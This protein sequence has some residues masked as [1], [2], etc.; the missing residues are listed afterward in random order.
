MYHTTIFLEVDDTL[1]GIGLLERNWEPEAMGPL[2]AAWD[3]NLSPPRW[4]SGL[5]WYV[6]VRGNRVGHYI[7]HWRF[8]W[9]VLLV[10]DWKGTEW[11]AISLNG[12]VTSG[13]IWYV[14]EREQNDTLY[15]LNKRN[16][17]VILSGTW[18]RGNRM[19]CYVLYWRS[20]GVV[21]TWYVTERE[22]N[23]WDN[24]SICMSQS[25]V[26]LHWDGVFRLRA[27]VITEQWKVT[28]FR[29]RL[30]EKTAPR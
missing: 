22:Q 29:L 9:V 17:Q 3:T 27:N 15:I 6:T 23:L 5:M 25:A 26:S 13:L 10:C 18:L 16:D 7:C 21:L 30:Q 14:A 28:V 12:V 4:L 8:D 11:Y 20:D 2:D 19:L 1:F 24:L